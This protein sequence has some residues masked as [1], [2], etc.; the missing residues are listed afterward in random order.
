MTLGWLA[1]FLS[2]PLTSLRHQKCDPLLRW[3]QQP[4][5][6]VFLS[7]LPPLESCWQ[8]LSWVQEGGW[9]A[10]GRA[11]PTHATHISTVTRRPAGPAASL[12][13]TLAVCCCC[14]CRSVGFPVHFRSSCRDNGYADLLCR[15]HRVPVRHL[16]SS[17]SYGNL[18][19]NKDKN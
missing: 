5:N 16:P 17:R 14:C 6:T 12:T 2:L 10:A 13:K 7:C 3:T 9:L 4:H 11:G 15:T 1:A 8:G 19:T 18:V